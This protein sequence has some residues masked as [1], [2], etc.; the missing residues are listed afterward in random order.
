[1]STHIETLVA[2]NSDF[3][4][5]ALLVGEDGSTPVDEDGIVTEILMTLRDVAGGVLL[6]EDEDVTDGLTAVVT[7]PAGN[8]NFTVQLTAAYNKVITGSGE[9]QLRLLTLKVTHSAGLKRNQEFTYYVDAMQD[10][11]DTP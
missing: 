8:Y 9:H 7:D 5:R 2:E 6:A 3:P 4:F 10:V 1:M 11:A